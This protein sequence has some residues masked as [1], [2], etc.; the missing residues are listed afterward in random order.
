[1]EYIIT[2]KLLNQ[3]LILITDKGYLKCDD[4]TIS[5]AF[6]E[7]GKFSCKIKRPEHSKRDFVIKYPEMNKS[8]EF[9]IMLSEYLFNQYDFEIDNWSKDNDV[10][11]L[12]AHVI[13]N[14]LHEF[15]HVIDYINRL[16]NGGDLVNRA[17]MNE[18][19]KY[20]EVSKIEDR[21]KRFYAYRRIDNEAHADE[22][23]MM[24]MERHKHEL[25][26]L[27]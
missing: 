23:A 16:N 14:I 10:S 22:I 9:D 3:I 4:Y 1:M 5:V 17:E 8:R 19:S 2:K 15:G 20:W 7:V 25:R 21:E 18:L 13:F 24:I 26:A 11:L 6:E 27:I 12:E